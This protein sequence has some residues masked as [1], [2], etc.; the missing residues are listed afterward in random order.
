MKTKIVTALFIAGIMTLSHG[1]VYGEEL[2]GEEVKEELLTSGNDL[3]MV[4]TEVI[5]IPE[6]LEIK[7]VVA[8]HMNGTFLLSGDT[9]S[10]SFRV[11]GTNELPKN[12]SLYF[13]ATWLSNTELDGLSFSLQEEN[14][15][16]V[17]NLE[18]P[19]FENSNLVVNQNE[20]RF[21]FSSAIM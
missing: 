5:E 20:M 14:Q 11:T 8:S 13:Y 1:I 15:R 16:Y 4:G 2:T 19:Y 7:D 10:L 3:P 21:S 18:L 9:Y 17:C 6:P 12:I